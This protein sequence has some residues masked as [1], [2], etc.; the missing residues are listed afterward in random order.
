M[1]VLARIQEELRDIGACI[2]HT[3]AA[4]AGAPTSNSALLTLQS[5]EK[6]QRVLEEQFLT[7]ASEMEL[8]VCSYRV[9]SEEERPQI[10]GLASVLAD[11][12]KLFSVTYAAIREKKPRERSRI[13]AL[14]AA[15]TSFG[16]AYSFA[17]S[18][19]FVLTL[20]ND[21]SSLYDTDLDET[22][23]IVFS[24]ARTP[25]PDAIVEYARQYGPAP[26]RALYKWAD[27]HVEYSSGVG[28]EWRRLHDIRSELLIQRP[29]LAQLRDAI[30]LTSD[31]RSTRIEVAGELVGIDVQRRTFHLKTDQRDY[32]GALSD[33]ITLA[34][35]VPQRYQAVL[36][37]RVVTKFSTDEESTIFVLETLSR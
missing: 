8:D 20:P 24:M 14:T 31:V 21:Q 6:R 13:K 27:H 17:G 4:L 16:F 12:Q 2:A 7:A 11:F 15:Q 33:A 32:T 9:F 36:E 5:L 23:R 10:A 37:E 29:E 22:M 30:A 25:R 3:E 19:G 18:V 34:V 35:E 28:I 1:S 26:I